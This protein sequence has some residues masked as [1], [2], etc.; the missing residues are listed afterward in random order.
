MR[1]PSAKWHVSVAGNAHNNNKTG[2]YW[3]YRNKITFRFIWHHFRFGRLTTTSAR[4]WT[5]HSIRA[6][7]L[8]AIVFYIWAT[9]LA[10]GSLVGPSRQCSVLIAIDW[11]KCCRLRRLHWRCVACLR[12]QHNLAT[13]MLMIGGRLARH[14]YPECRA[15]D[16]MG[17]IV[18]A[19]GGVDFFSKLKHCHWCVCSLNGNHKNET[20]NSKSCELLNCRH[21]SLQFRKITINFLPFGARLFGKFLRSHHAWVRRASV[22][23]FVF[24]YSASTMKVW[25]FFRSGAFT[26]RRRTVTTTMAEWMNSSRNMTSDKLLICHLCFTFESERLSNRTVLDA[27]ECT[28]IRHCRI[29]RCVTRNGSTEIISVLGA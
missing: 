6:L 10:D 24:H 27:I 7:V 12:G 21:P 11:K 18:C 15:V 26:Y 19:R 13:L 23:S 1:R 20:K 5:L 14:A 8:F 29:T 3:L 25:M 16:T 28:D 17:L 4:W 2:Q 22:S 9:S